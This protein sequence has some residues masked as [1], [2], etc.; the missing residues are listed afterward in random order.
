LI[1]NLALQSLLASQSAALTVV[2]V[3]RRMAEKAR[4]ILW[5]PGFQRGLPINYH[6]S[7]FALLKASS[8]RQNRTQTV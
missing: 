2:Q 8:G 1:K 7:V 5:M 6:F 4:A 3:S